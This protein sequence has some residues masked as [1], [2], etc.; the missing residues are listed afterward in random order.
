[1]EHIVILSDNYTYIHTKQGESLNLIG[2]ICKVETENGPLHFKMS[3]ES[4]TTFSG[5]RLQQDQYNN[6]K[7]YITDEE[8]VWHGIISDG[9]F[10]K[11]RWI[12]LY[13]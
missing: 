11:G 13:N 7:F 4:P 1:M 3:R 12:Y 10:S 2:R 8:N 5:F 9:S 6:K